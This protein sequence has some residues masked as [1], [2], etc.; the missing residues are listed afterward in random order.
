[1]RASVLFLGL[2]SAISS[3]ARMDWRDTREAWTW[4][5]L[6]NFIGIRI[7]VYDNLFLTKGIHSMKFEAL[8]LSGFKETRSVR[9]FLEASSFLTAMAPTIPACQTS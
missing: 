6:S 7:E 2:R 9:T 5:P 3:L 4:R 1:M 8:T